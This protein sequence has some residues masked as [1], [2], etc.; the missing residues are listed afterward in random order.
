MRTSKTLRK[1]SRVVPAAS[2]QAQL[3]VRQP[4]GGVRR[5]WDRRNRPGR[6]A[7][8]P[9]PVKA[10]LRIVGP[11]A[12]TLTRKLAEG[13]E[14]SLWATAWEHGRQRFLSFNFSSSSPAVARIA[15][16][17]PDWATVIGVSAGWATLTAAADGA[18]ASLRLRVA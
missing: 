9:V 6:L 4:F 15:A 11:W 12:V 3:P 7:D 5:R 1:P 10:W 13:E 14:A 17:G 8:R 18:R 16:R 2:R